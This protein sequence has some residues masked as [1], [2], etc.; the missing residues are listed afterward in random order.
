MPLI[1][2]SKSTKLYHCDT[3]SLGRNTILAEQFINERSIPHTNYAFNT[4]LQVH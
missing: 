4:H 3:V 2:T 1:L